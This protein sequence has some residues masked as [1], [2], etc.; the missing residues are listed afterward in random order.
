M[1]KC[2]R[3]VARTTKKMLTRLDTNHHNNFSSMATEVVAE[4]EVG[5]ATKTTE[6]VIIIHTVAA[7]KTGDVEAT[8]TTM[9]AVIITLT[10]VVATNREVVEVMTTKM[11]DKE[12]EVTG[13]VMVAIV[14]EV[15]V[16][17]T[18]TTTI[19]N[20]GIIKE[21]NVNMVKRHKKRTDLRRLYCA[22][23]IHK[24]ESLNQNT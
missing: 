24:L 16:I 8:K 10:E 12:I 4:A 14:M 23:I 1:T 11:E 5:E 20:G 21:V 6:K 19:T 13:V 15:E 22:Y 3:I 17:R 9:K 18:K 2:G 7:T